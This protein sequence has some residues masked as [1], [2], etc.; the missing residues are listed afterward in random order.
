VIANHDVVNSVSDIDE[1]CSLVAED[2]RR[3]YRIV[4]GARDGV[5]MTDARR[6]HLD[7]HLAA[8]GGSRVSD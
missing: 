7:K 1:A 8:R 5:G 4:A 2:H 6:H 3:R